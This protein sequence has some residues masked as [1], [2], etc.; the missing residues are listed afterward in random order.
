[1][2]ETKG[3]PV[4]RNGR[5]VVPARLC[6]VALAAIFAITLASAH[7]PVVDSDLERV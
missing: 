4:S 5:L 7:S 1:M 6:A 2:N 3:I